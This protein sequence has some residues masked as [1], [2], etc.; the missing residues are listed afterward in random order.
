MTQQHTQQYTVVIGLGLTGVSILRH[1]SAQGEHCLAMDTRSNP[2]G[3]V[4]I[5]LE[6]PQLPIHLGPLDAKICAHAKRIVVSPGISLQEPVLI[7][8]KQAGVPIIS[9]LDLFFSENQA[10]VIAITGSNGKTTVTTLV[11]EC[12]V[13]CGFSVSVCGNIGRPVLD[14]LCD[15]PADY[16]VIE[17]SSFQLE[18]SDSFSPEVA[19]CLNV[20]PDHLDRH[21]TVSAYRAA[22][23]RIYRG[24][25]TALVN[26][27]ADAGYQYAPE[28][29]QRVLSFGSDQSADISVCKTGVKSV[30]TVL[31]AAALDVTGYS[32]QRQSN[33]MAC[34]AILEAQDI[35]WAPAVS[36]IENFAGLAHR[37]Q[38]IRT[39]DEV[40]YINDSKATN[41]GAAISALHSAVTRYQ[42]VILIAGGQS[43]GVS[44]D[45][46]AGPVAQSCRGVVLFGQDAALFDEALSESGVRITHVASLSEAV[47]VAAAQAKAG[48]L[49]LLSPAAASFDMFESYEQRGDIFIK[50]VQSL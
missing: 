3:K 23:L 32:P 12:L 43:K 48:D 5:E 30:I 41:V 42:K 37:Y 1:L 21:G 24:A 28:K 9:D 4:I 22:K 7:G 40:D 8:A 33:A 14:T 2:S 49:V 29:N 47:A 15:K 6:Y 34:L 39:V 26:A 10:K 16:R 36:T 44:L 17:L 19:V 18:A 38:W 25:E 27:D 46:L 13:A 31:G 20:S 11:G 45:G 50:C 35:D